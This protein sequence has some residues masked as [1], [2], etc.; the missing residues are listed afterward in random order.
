MSTTV[1][2]LYTRDSEILGLFRP[3]HL[4]SRRYCE[5]A[6]SAMLFHY[7]LS[8]DDRLA[9]QA[10]VAFAASIQP[11]GLI[12]G[13]Y[14]AHGTQIITGFAL[15][16][17]LQVCDHML[18]FSDK[19]FAE[20]FLNTIDSVFTY[21]EGKVCPTTG[22][23]SGLPPN[24]WSFVDWHEAWTEDQTF[25]DPGVPRAGRKTATWSFFSM[26]YVYTLRQA[27]KLLRQ[28]DKPALFHEYT[29]RA[30]RTT[31]AVIKHCFDGRYF[32]DSIASLEDEDE[33]RAD[34]PHYSQHSQLWAILCGAVAPEEL[35]TLGRRLMSDAFA[36]SND[37]RGIFAA[38][39]Y[40]M[41][42]Y[43][44]RAL[45]SVGLYDDLFEYMWDPWRRMIANNLTTWQEDEVNA[46]SDCH[47]WSSLPIWEFATEV[48]GLTP[49]R[50]G[51]TKVLF[52][53]RVALAPELDA[54]V[55][56]GNRGLATVVWSKSKTD[57]GSVRVQLRL[58]QPT[59][60]VSRLP[61]KGEVDHGVVQ[62]LE[63]V[64]TISG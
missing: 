57:H 25:L 63:T 30:D 27:C 20:R 59:A 24:Y 12:C 43:A 29:A 7:V 4:C 56:M 16:W 49:L 54:A 34:A 55:N 1:Q 40:P 28:L 42:H 6:R 61:G 51:W 3:T 32:T 38:C 36:F 31:K 26:L 11:D 9:R 37:A 14:P 52:A 53:P 15:F 60:L 47:E 48:A 62:G 58:P 10:I 21:F 5:D 23:V 39:S 33:D 2:A 46:R 45:S 19:V 41:L 17:V 64:I 8:G 18:H 22:L 13:R 44:F 35:P 50:P